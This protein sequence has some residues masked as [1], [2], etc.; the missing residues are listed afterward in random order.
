MKE[1]LK[2]GFSFGLT[3]AMIT[4]LGLIV[5]LVYSTNSKLIV[6]TGILTIAI[7]DAFSDALGIHISEESQKNTKDKTIWE[8]TLS[9]YFA[10]LFFAL[11]FIIPFLLFSI[12]IA[13]YASIGYGLI[14][15]AILSYYIAKEK[16]ESKF[17]VI[18]EHLGIGILVII[19]SNLVGT[20]LN[21]FI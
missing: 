12:R 4:T 17:K 18:A 3:S 7:A 2:K 16:K 5:G 10:K 8:A 13:M 11:L 19:I 9:T 14:T 20:Y 6:I 15:L 1:S 21:K